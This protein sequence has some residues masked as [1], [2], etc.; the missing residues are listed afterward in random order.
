MQ[1]RRAVLLALGDSL[2]VQKRGLVA[3]RIVDALRAGGF[4]GG[5]EQHYS[6]TRFAMLIE[7]CD[8]Y[9]TKQ[10]RLLKIAPV[11]RDDRGWMIPASSGQR[12][13]DEHTFEK[14]REVSAKDTGA[15]GE[16]NNTKL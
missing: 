11:Y 10:I 12:W 3:M 4:I 9:V 5:I 15:M 16:K 13:L 14:S 6:A 8:E 7:R 1:A 2:P